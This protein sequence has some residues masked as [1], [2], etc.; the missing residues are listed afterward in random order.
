MIPIPTK[1]TKGRKHV[2]LKESSLRHQK[3]KKDAIIGEILTSAIM[4]KIA[5]EKK[6]LKDFEETGRT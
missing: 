2:T 5:S 4:Q 3:E 6:E 1:V